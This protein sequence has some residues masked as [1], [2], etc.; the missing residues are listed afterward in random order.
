VITY[1]NLFGEDTLVLN[2]IA[3]F[4]VAKLLSVVCVIFSI[5]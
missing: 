1:P 3:A 2:A 4:L 5:A